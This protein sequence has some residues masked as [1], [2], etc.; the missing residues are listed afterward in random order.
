MSKSIV[1]NSIYN[2]IYKG[3]TALFPL[4]TMTYICRVLLAEGVGKVSYANTVATY[5]VLIASLG[6]PNYGIKA[7][8]QSNRDLKER[9]TVLMEL[10]SIN[11]ISTTIC[12]IIYFIFINNCTYFAGRTNLFN[13]F[14][15]LI[16]LNYFNFD[17][18]YQGIEEYSYIATRSIIIKILSFV[19]ML[20]FVKTP[21]DYVNYACILC[22]ATAGN[23]ILNAFNLRKYF[24]LN[25]NKLNFVRHLKPVFILLASTVAQELYTMLD[26]IMLEFFHG[27]I[28][29]GYYSNSVKIIRMVYTLTIAMVGAFYPRISKLIKEKNSEEYNK[30]LSIGLKIILLICVPG[31]VGIFTI[32][33]SLIRVFLGESFIPSILCVRVLSGLIIIFSVAYFLG[34]IVAMAAGQEKNILK[35]TVLGAIT[36]FILNIIL[37]PK[38]KH[39]GAAI[40][41][42]IAEI[43]VTVVLIKN[44]KNVFKLDIKINYYISILI[45]SIIMGIVVYI[46]NKYFSNYFIALIISLVLG[47]SIYLI[48]LVILKNDLLYYFVNK[49]LKRK[50]RIE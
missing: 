3:F 48:G 38:F 34:H 42:V 15:S 30:L 13:V 46:I 6:I 33:P 2:I 37:I 32:A 8:A 50:E 49:F 40:A 45:P 41:S 26:T 29:V 16:L 24:T 4:V 36:N 19:L 28:Y 23:Y 17:W 25:F 22:I 12:A 39:Y 44:T 18:F 31:S 9:N 47:G 21:N 20:F 10:F 7:I 14:G 27:E 1:K 43:V 5:F 11:F 35:A